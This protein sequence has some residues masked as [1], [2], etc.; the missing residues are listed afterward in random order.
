MSLNLD[1]KL[2]IYD[3]GSSPLQNV[4]EKILGADSAVAKL[5]KSF[6]GMF[7]VMAQLK[8][9]NI[10]NNL[11]L[12]KFAALE[13]QQIVVKNSTQAFGNSI[14]TL[15]QKIH[16]LQGERDL[17]PQSAIN[18]IRKY[19]SEIKSLEA[20]IQHLSTINGGG[21][22]SKIGEAMQ[23]IPFAGMMTNPFLIA[24]AVAGK[25]LQT[26]IQ[27]EMQKASFDT[28]LGSKEAGKAMFDDIAQYAKDS[29]FE[30]MGLGDN[31]K[32][33]LGYGINAEK[34]MPSMKMLGDVAMGDQN[35]L[36]LLT[37]AFSQISATGHLM[38]Q[39]MH[40]LVNAGFNPL[41]EISKMTGESMETLK[42]RMEDGKI[43]IAEVEGAF[44]HATSEG[45]MFYGMA[46]KMG[47]TLGGR[48]STFMD[49]LAELG[50]KIYEA[51]E[52]IV[53]PIVEFLILGVGWLGESLGSLIA[54]FKEGSITGMIIA[55][56]LS[57]LVI[58]Y[59]AVSLWT[60]IN[61]AMT[62]LQ[63]DAMIA[64]NASFLANP[65]FWVVGAF[66]ALT[67]GLVYAWNHFEGFRKFLYGLWESFKQVFSNI[68]KFFTQIFSP[69]GE[70]IAAFQKGDWAGVAIGAAKLGA[71]LLTAPA[72]FVAY[73][74]SGE[75][76]KGVGQAYKKGEAMGSAS[77]KSDQKKKEEEKS[78]SKA[79]KSP[80]D[81]IKSDGGKKDSTDN[82]KGADGKSTGSSGGGSGKSVTVHID[83][84]FENIQIYTTS[85]KE[86]ESEIRRR[87]SEMVIAGVGDAEV[88]LAN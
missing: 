10:G 18:S 69:I 9:V 68:G 79:T 86:G 35:K 20:R 67:A 28:I 37:Y 62:W 63:N 78:T 66:V 24:G 51:L 32:T 56:V 25:S 14:E 4:I 11:G 71:N 7:D 82:K 73:A 23:Q 49:T 88:A 74:L 29:P 42:K 22:Q 60:G 26:G 72:Q 2:T 47:K 1:Y 70:T 81:L 83:K 54:S 64:L 55:G 41:K 58:G 43:S 52:P 30:K 12:E 84:I 31:A 45:G 13:K 6:G 87:I 44:K 80:A 34:I 65:I 16:L 85:L 75:L 19:N 46:D 40:Q 61:T 17:L 3:E 21:I 39:D 77:F 76:T 59:A 15:R 48:W 50:L 38:G 33:M 27:M 5:Q 8:S 53:K 36:N 57:A